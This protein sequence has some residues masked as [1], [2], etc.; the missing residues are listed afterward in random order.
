MLKN[1]KIL[2]SC[3]C[4][5][6]NEKHPVKRRMFKNVSRRGRSERRAEAYA[7][8]VEALS[9]AKTKPGGLFGHSARRRGFVDLPKTY[10]NGVGRIP[11][12]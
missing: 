6:K 10:S 7:V 3:S 5:M 8:Y 2:R 9:D 4:D 11:H 12:T 1:L